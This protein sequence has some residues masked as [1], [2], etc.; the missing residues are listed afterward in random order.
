MAGNADDLKVLESIV[1]PNEP[2]GDVVDIPSVP[3][4]VGAAQVA[5][6]ALLLPND[7]VLVGR[8]LLPR[9]RRLEQLHKG[10]AP[11]AGQRLAAIDKLSF[12]LPLEGGGEDLADKGLGC[13]LV[14]DGGSVFLVNPH[15]LRDTPST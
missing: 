5:K 10:P 14:D 2:R 4:D 12:G 6:A 15:G 8:Q 3:G 7:L 13:S 11:N 9:W 1:S